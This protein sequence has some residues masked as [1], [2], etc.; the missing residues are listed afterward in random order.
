MAEGNFFDVHFGNSD[1][2]G[3]FEGFDL[4]NIAPS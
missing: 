3:K 1:F 2:D 4:G